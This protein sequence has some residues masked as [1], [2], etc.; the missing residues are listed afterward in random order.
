MKTI[1]VI[2]QTCI[3][4]KQG[5]TTFF[6]KIKTTS[7]NRFINAPA[8]W[9]VIGALIGALTVS[10]GGCGF[11]LK[12]PVQLPFKSIYGNFTQQ[13]P[14]GQALKRAI[15]ASDGLELITDP[16]RMDKAQVILEVVHEFKDKVI[17]GRTA[18]GTV[19]AY[20]LRL[21]VTFKLRTQDGIELIPETDISL[22]RDISF[23][24]TIVLSKEAEEQLLYKN[25]QNDIAE[26]IMRRISSAGKIWLDGLH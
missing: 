16:K 1:A 10:L 23:N 7:S 11:E 26:Q 5:V 21:M 13:T 18:A 4:V 25:M 24:E 9:I 15:L 12:K 2:W 19:N 17:L 8:Y 3:V 22:F 6:K 14:F 20:Q